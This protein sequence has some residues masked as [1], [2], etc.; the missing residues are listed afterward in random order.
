MISVIFWKKVLQWTKYETT[1]T[2][3][4]QI[5]ISLGLVEIFF[6]YLASLSPRRKTVEQHVISVSNFGPINN[7]FLET[8]YFNN[9]KFKIRS[10]CDFTRFQFGMV[11]YGGPGM[12]NLFLNFVFNY[13]LIQFFTLFYILLT[14]LVLFFRIPLSQFFH[15]KNLMKRKPRWQVQK[16]HSWVMI[17]FF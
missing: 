16:W 7:T 11:L 3:D 14:I 12:P 2:T 13:L 9:L 1:T 15:K 4:S 6:L 5:Y 8:F 10:I 17:L